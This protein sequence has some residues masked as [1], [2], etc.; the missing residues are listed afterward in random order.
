MFLAPT[1][2][3]PAKKRAKMIDWQT[4]DTTYVNFGENFQ[5]S[6]T[7]T[8]NNPRELEYTIESVLI[9][10]KNQKNINAWLL[11][12]RTNSN[13]ITL[14]YLHGNGGNIMMQYQSFIPF[15]K[16]GYSIF[17]PDYSGYGFSEG[18]ATRSNV[19]S[20]ALAAFNYMKQREDQ[21]NNKVIIYGQSLGGHLSAVVAQK[22]EKDIDGLVIEGAFSSHK[23]IAANRA[24]FIGRWFVK[25]KYSAKKSI[26]GFHKPVLIIHSTEDKVI[27]FSHGK[28]L[29]EKANE[30]KQFYEIQ[31][32]H[33]CG[34]VYYNDS[35]AARINSLI[36]K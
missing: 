1:K 12:P 18:K 26:A 35:I 4:R 29:F 32:C 11:K 33:V 14:F 23:D 36:T 27:P 5:P 10:N 15:I 31:K 19:L 6:F 9:K 30:P 7:D 34:P 16:K 3:D 20:D 17:I 28:K 22:V 25:E 24:G 2:I 8:K 21:K 13:N